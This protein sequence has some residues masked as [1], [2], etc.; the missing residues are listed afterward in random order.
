MNKQARMVKAIALL[1]GGLDS[2][3]AVKLI[4]E[5]GI[6]VVC[7]NF[8]TPFCNCN[9]KDGCQSE[10]KRVCS[11]FG[12]NLKVISL[13]DEYFEIVRN[14]KHGYGANMNPCL[15]CRILMLKKAKAY[16]E[17]IGASF[18]ITGEVL[19]QRPMSQRRDAM[20]IIERKAGVEEF[21]LRPLSARH[22]DPTIPEIEGIIDRQ[23]L[24]AF[25]GR[26]RKPQIALADEY[27][28][29]DYPCPAGGCL[30]TDP[31]FAKR[32]RD[33]ITHKP[34]FNINDVQLLKIGRHFRLTPEAKLIVGRNQEENQRLSSLAQ[35]HDLSLWPT[36]TKG[37][38]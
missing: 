24:L 19:G 8:V 23:R 36:Q 21:I 15:D 3:L 1:S 6:E 26:S 18:I 9:R 29:K 28:L 5:Q 11:E 32:M 13:V 31:E 14:P 35:E 2:T 4:L 20:R 17:E 7:L 25:S 16:M 22:F 30:L 34:D 27:G 12:L 33:L 10:A 38:V 37:P